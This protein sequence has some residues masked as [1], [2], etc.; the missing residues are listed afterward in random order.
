LQGTLKPVIRA[1]VV[2]QPAVSDSPVKVLIDSQCNFV[3]PSVS[4][5]LV[6]SESH[7]ALPSSEHRRQYCWRENGFGITSFQM[8]EIEEE[9]G[10]LMAS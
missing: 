6:S 4:D 7:W 1:D 8:K 3:L 5:E 9:S 10:D 2:R